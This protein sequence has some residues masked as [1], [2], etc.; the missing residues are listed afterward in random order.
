MKKSKIIA[1]LM[2]TAC[3]TTVFAG[4]K[5]EIDCTKHVDADKNGSCD[6]CGQAVQ[7]IVE[8]L[9]AEKEEVVDMVVNPLPAESKISEYIG[10][11]AEVEEVVTPFVDFEKTTVFDDKVFVSYSNNL[12][13][14]VEQ[15]K[16]DNAE[17]PDVVEETEYKHTIYDTVAKKELYTGTS[18]A[19][20]VSTESSTHKNVKISFATNY[21]KVVEHTY[22]NDGYSS[23]QKSAVTKYYTR[24]GELIVTLPEENADPNYYYSGVESFFNSHNG[25]SIAQSTLGDY[26]YLTAT[27]TVDNNNG[28]ETEKNTV[29]TIDTKTHTLVKLEGATG[30][31]ETFIKRPV[32]NVIKGDYGYVY[33]GSEIWVYDLTKWVS[34][35]YYNKV[36]SNWKD[37]N[38][39]VL[40]NGKIFVQYKFQLMDNAVNYDIMEDVSGE[41]KKFDLVQ[42]L[43]NPVDGAMEEVEFGYVFNNMGASAAAKYN[44]NAKNLLYLTPIVDKKVEDSAK[45]E[46]VLDDSLNI[47][48]AH[49]ATIVGQD[50]DTLT[51]VAEN[52]YETTVNYGGGV[53]VDV[54]VDGTGKEVMKIPT[55]AGD[56]Y[57]YY[58]VGTGIYKYSD[59]TVAGKLFDL[60]DYDADFER[61]FSSYAL[62]RKT[63]YIPQP[64]GDP[65]PNYTYYYFNETMTAPKAM[66]TGEVVVSAN[67][68]Y[69]V[70]SRIVKV[71]DTTNK[72]VYDLYNSLGEKIVTSDSSDFDYD[73]HGDNVVS[74]N[75]T[76]TT[77]TG[78]VTDRVYF[79]KK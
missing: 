21:I 2:A 5:D 43:I 15:T 25:V 19:K 50:I 61:E 78:D 31:A 54:Y 24:T 11:K 27:T 53:T 57:G 60:S 44:D 33:N 38:A 9:P 70:V 41:T 10:P 52:L 65:I 6:T 40:D 72:T 12:L 75:V 74:V 34:C 79:I 32:F 36:S 23:A 3:L 30:E 62:F 56:Y 48:Y 47:L 46:A 16:W 26:V 66:A 77:D 22:K 7:I 49:K 39:T 51:Y 67:E 58:Q 71:D 63:D 69:Y 18:G 13:H 8:Q 64:E 20:G 68:D 29:Y 55:N 45:F 4:C 37:V 35:V 59:M 73:T 14:V 76:T 17:T 1:L 42:L 28:S